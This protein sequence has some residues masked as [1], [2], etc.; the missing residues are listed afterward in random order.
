[1]V[2]SVR[3]D[4]WLWAI[5][6]FKTRTLATEACKGGRVKM[7]GQNVKASREVKEGDVIDI[8]QGIIKKTFRV[9]VAAK[10]R[11][12]AK[13]VPDLAEDLTPPEEL[14]K[15]QMLRQLNHEK[16]DRGT[17]RPT[18]RDRRDIDSLKDQH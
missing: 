17:G 18:K 1:M 16:R 11:V 6:V 7:D 4:K 12:S 5:R 3:I 13:L 15:Q 2:N 9:K 8:Q 10:N 14:E